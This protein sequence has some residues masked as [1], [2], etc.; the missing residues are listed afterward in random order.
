MLDAWARLRTRHGAVFTP[1]EARWRLPV[2][3]LLLTALVVY[4]AV[5]EDLPTPSLWWQVA[6]VSLLVMPATFAMTYLA[7]PL[8]TALSSHK[9]A[10]TVVAFA[11][12]TLVLSLLGADI[13]ANFTKFFAVTLAGWWFLRFF[14]AVSW[15]LL[16]AVLIVP[17]DI[18][19]VAR[20]PTKTIVEQQP[21]V[22]DALSIAFPV[23][24]EHTAAQLGLPD[25]MFFA[26]FLGACARFGLRLRW[27]WLA[28]TLSFGATLAIAVQWDVSGLP[29][30][31]L[32][33]VAFVLVNA[34]LLWRGLR[35]QRL[36]L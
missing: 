18:Y 22:F 3:A 25:V 7:L 27:T 8:R 5:A 20:G 35:Q 31:P 36:G 14:E 10:A 17:V 32:L 33:S 30:L 23:P 13:A 28:M 12:A 21:Q 11:V 26:L 29:A 9:L 6:V 19:S 15:V 1:P 4:D 34:D 16:V 24:G 2:G